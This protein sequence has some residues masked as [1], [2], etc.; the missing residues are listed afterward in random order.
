VAQCLAAWL[1]EGRLLQPA[2]LHH[3]DVPTEGVEDRGEAA[4]Q[5]FVGDSV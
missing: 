3:H 4:K 1:S 2:M 5:A